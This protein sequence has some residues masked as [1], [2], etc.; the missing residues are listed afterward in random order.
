MVWM[1]GLFM[2][3]LR[4][5]VSAESRWQTPVDSMRRV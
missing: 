5:K 4:E 2:F 1:V 3:W